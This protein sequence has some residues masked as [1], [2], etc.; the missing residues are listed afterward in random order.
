MKRMGNTGREMV[1]SGAWIKVAR[2]HYRHID[3]I[4]VRYN[5]NRY[6]WEI[7]GKDEA[8]GLLWVARGRAEKLSATTC[9]RCG[10]SECGLVCRIARA[11]LATA[12]TV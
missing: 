9:A 2:K 11:K 6:A 3:G 4:E 7:L 8:Y 12:V 1:D 5:G 10:A